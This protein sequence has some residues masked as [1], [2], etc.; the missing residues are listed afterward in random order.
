M[1]Y[2][3]VY[4]DELLSRRL[5]TIQLC[6][7]CGDEILK[8]KVVCD[9]CKTKELREQQHRNNTE[10]FAEAGLPPYVCKVCAKLL[11]KHNV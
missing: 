11:A 3:E 10:T 6:W 1:S 7:H 9:N 5:P 2:I 4:Q 8:T